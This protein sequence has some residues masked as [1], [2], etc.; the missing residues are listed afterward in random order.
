[1]DFAEDFNLISVFRVF[2]GGRALI[3]VDMC[4]VWDCHPVSAVPRG[5][6]DISRL[7]CLNRHL[8]L[9][10]AKEIVM[11]NVDGRIVSGTSSVGL[12]PEN[13]L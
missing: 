12:Q 1:M 9:Y 2:F 7:R 3:E 8:R 10:H 11:S 6:F 5:S 13:L 4:F